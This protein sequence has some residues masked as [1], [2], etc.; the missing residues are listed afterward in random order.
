M[1]TAL[2]GSGHLSASQQK[3]QNPQGYRSGPT[4]TALMTQDS[5]HLDTSRKEWGCIHQS[6][7]YPQDLRSSYQV[8]L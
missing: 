6:L 2:L 7:F 8:A 4:F 3:T 5:S 1:S